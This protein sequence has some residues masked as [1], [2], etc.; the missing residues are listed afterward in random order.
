MNPSPTFPDMVSIPGPK[1]FLGMSAAADH[2]GMNEPAWR[3]MIRL[4]GGPPSIKVGRR[5]FFLRETLD[6]W[7]RDQQTPST[8][9][10]HRPPSYYVPKN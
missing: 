4:T 3:R 2:V 7:L 10:T 1:N 5:Q 8:A 9:T 6:Q